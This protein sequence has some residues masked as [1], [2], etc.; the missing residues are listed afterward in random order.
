MTGEH[1][2]PSG[3]TNEFGDDRAWKMAKKDGMN[4]LLSMPGGQ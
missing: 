3:M 1:K 4:I 2:L